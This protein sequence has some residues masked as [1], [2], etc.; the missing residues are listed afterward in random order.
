MV[1]DADTFFRTLLFV[2]DMQWGADTAPR[3]GEEGDAALRQYVQKRW[4]LRKSLD[5][6]DGLSTRGAADVGLPG[7]WSRSAVCFHLALAQR[8]DPAEGPRDRMHPTPAFDDEYRYAPYGQRIVSSELQKLYLCL[9]PVCHGLLSLPPFTQ[10][11]LHLRRDALRRSQANQSLAERHAATDRIVDIIAQPSWFIL[12]VRQLLGVRCETAAELVCGS[13]SQALRRCFHRHERGGPQMNAASFAA[14]WVPILLG[15]ATKRLRRHLSR[16]Y[17][18][19][20]TADLE[21]DLGEVSRLRRRLPSRGLVTHLLFARLLYC[22]FYAL[23]SRRDPFWGRT[24]HEWLGKQIISV[25]D[26]LL[27]H[28]AGF[29]S[30][31][32]A[33]EHRRIAEETRA[34]LPCSSHLLA[35]A[36]FHF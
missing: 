17:A 13:F 4:W 34:Q 19:H 23:E 16:E 6:S 7:P 24:S 18:L 25:A 15:I 9:T 22:H 26:T 28:V 8:A 1:L 14:L 30:T 33:R 2:V 12:L 5:R 21:L 31:T 27:A 29:G 20:Y 36:S 10:L 11:R 35:R 3:D 32:R